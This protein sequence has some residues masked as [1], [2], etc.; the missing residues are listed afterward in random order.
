MVMCDEVRCVSVS[1][2]LFGEHYSPLS[3]AVVTPHILQQMSGGGINRHTVCT[4][5]ATAGCGVN[6]AAGKVQATVCNVCRVISLSS[7][8]ML[9][10]EPFVCDMCAV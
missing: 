6:R 7:G 10:Y 3:G 5:A 2:W 9:F 8:Y 1:P 4:G